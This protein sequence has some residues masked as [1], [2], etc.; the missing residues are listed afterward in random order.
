M[1]ESGG[2]EPG[3]ILCYGDDPAEFDYGF[4]KLFK[5]SMQNGYI[6]RIQIED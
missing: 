6:I 5:G 3:E 4:F 2:M 1:D